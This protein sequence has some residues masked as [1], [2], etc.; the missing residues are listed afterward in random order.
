MPN[1]GFTLAEDAALKRRLSALSVSDDRNVERVPKVFFRYPEGET[2]NEYPF[3]TIDLV[4]IS[5]VAGRQESERTYFF[6]DTGHG[7]QSN[8]HFYPSEIDEAGMEAKADG[9]LL[10]TDQFVP[11]DLI[12]QITTHCRSQRHDRQLTMLLLRRVFPFRRGFIEVPEDGTIRRCDLM[13]WR[14]TDVLD[15]E[16][17]Y[18]KRIFRKVYTV[19]INAEIPQSDL[20]GAQQVQKVHGQ[21]S[22]HQTTPPLLTEDF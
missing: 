11:V 19:S 16:A 20:L 4:D 22:V 8:L 6:N 13:D 18:R 1:P 15:Q 5:Y 17:A 10:V 9:G 14:N 7:P 12:Y 2:E 21:L 3:V